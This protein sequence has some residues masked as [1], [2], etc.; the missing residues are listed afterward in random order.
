VWIDKEDFSNLLQVVEKSDR[1]KAAD[2]FKS[3]F[4]SS[5]SDEEALEFCLRHCVY[6]TYPPNSV[7]IVFTYLT[8]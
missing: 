3:A 2:F 1:K 5:I 8:V 4:P 7:S 6:Q